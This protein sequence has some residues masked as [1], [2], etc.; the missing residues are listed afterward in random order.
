MAYSRRRV[1]TRRRAVSRRAPARSGYSRGT[2]RR[3]TGRRSSA[4]RSYSGGARTIRI[5]VVSPAP[6]A[7]AR[8][9]I[10]MKAAEPARK[11]SA[12]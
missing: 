8:P 2:V 3:A 11:K 6:S 12:F 10:G 1:S 7:V 4:R 5:E 9:E